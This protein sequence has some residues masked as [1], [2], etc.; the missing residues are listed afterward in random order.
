[1]AIAGTILSVACDAVITEPDLKAASI[2]R[3][4]SDNAVISLRKNRQLDFGQKASQIKLN[5]FLLLFDK[6]HGF[7]RDM[8]YQPHFPIQLWFPKSMPRN[9]PEIT[10]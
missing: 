2:T 1:M 10:T 5:H 3:Q 4:P 6:Y 7:A 8:E 9:I